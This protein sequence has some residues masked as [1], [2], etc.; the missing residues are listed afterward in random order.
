MK[1]IGNYLS[2]GKKVE[3]RP[4]SEVISSIKI[5]Y[6]QLCNTMLFSS[7]QVKLFILRRR[8]AL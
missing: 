7:L 6:L 8:T 2:S 3:K 1:Y 4:V 5:K